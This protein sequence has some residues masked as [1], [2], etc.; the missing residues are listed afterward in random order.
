[1]KIGSFYHDLRFCSLRI[2]TVANCRC[3]KDDCFLQ[4]LVA[5]IVVSDFLL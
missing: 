5:K 2:N 4:Q 1:M 3:T